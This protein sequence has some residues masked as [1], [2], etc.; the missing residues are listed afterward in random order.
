LH[1]PNRHLHQKPLAKGRKGKENL[2][3]A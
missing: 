3:W 2:C 1:S